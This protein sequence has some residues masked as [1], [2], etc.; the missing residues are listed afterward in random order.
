MNFVLVFKPTYWHA[1]R[2]SALFWNTKVFFYFRK[3]LNYMKE[4]ILEA[5]EA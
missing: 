2:K 1:S 4:A 3:L 5:T